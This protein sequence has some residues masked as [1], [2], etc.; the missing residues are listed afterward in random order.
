MSQSVARASKFRRPIRLVLDFDGT[1]TAKDTMHLVAQCGYKSFE[2]HPERKLRGKPYPK[3]PPWQYF[4]DAYM[5]DY[6]THKAK[7]RPRKE[8][9]KTVDQEIAW[10]RSLRPIEEAS[11]DRVVASGLYDCID[12]TDMSQAVSTAIEEHAL[13]FRPGLHALLTMTGAWNASV[14]DP[15]PSSAAPQS[16]IS[17]TPDLQIISVNWSRFWIAAA[18]EAHLSASELADQV[19]PKAR[20]YANEIPSL[21]DRDEWPQLSRWNL[22]SRHNDNAIKCRTSDDK[23]DQMKLCLEDRTSNEDISPLV[24]YVGDSATDLECL[25]AADI[26]ICIR[27]EPMGSSQR[28]LS[29]ICERVGIPVE[30]ISE[31]GVTLGSPR[32]DRLW[33]A[34]SFEE[35]AA[36]ISILTA[37]ETAVVSQEEKHS[38]EGAAK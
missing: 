38:Y 22:V 21:D 26:G 13:A 28:D 10:L 27:D 11:A 6:E 3:L 17:Q 34:S 32:S 14:A 20:V 18:L 23:V 9:R 4:V 30:K 8:D 2:R 33:W 7:F 35:I 19:V 15:Q 1:V 37:G 29:D 36:W 25:L 5:R 24:V 31:A 16:G 12:H